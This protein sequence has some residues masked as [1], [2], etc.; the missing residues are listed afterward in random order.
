MKR[1]LILLHGALGTDAQMFP[2][3]KQLSAHFKIQNVLFHGHGS[4]DAGAVFNMDSLAQQL[5]TSMQ[6]ER[7]LVF[8]YSMGGYVALTAA[9]I[10]PE[11]FEGVMT[12]GTKFDWS[13]DTLEKE[14][15]Q[16]RPDKIREKV[17]QL[18]KILEERHGAAWPQQAEATA[19][20]M[21]HLSARYRDIESTWT[22]MQRPVRLMLGDQDKM[23][24]L[25]ETNRVAAMLPDAEIKILEETPHQIERVH[26]VTLVTEILHFTGVLNHR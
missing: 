23:V 20:M 8:G 18:A 17:P 26:L 15:K 13:A 11:L 16:L 5:I 25:E 9:A 4:L 21:L 12:L 7:A 6:E 1:K 3:A 14:L 19:N 22:G 10:E 2:L 24:T